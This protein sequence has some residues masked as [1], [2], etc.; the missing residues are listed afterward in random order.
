MPERA[1]PRGEH[2][3]G[4]FFTPTAGNSLLMRI[5]LRTCWGATLPDRASQLAARPFAAGRS[6]EGRALHLSYAARTKK[7]IIFFVNA[8]AIRFSFL[9]EALGFL[10]LPFGWQ[11]RRQISIK[12]L[13]CARAEKK[14]A[15]TGRVHTKIQE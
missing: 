15:E 13:Q 3:E 2:S 4:V 1:K 5:E 10:A 8:F 14:I 12:I 11:K 6:E 9:V 7:S